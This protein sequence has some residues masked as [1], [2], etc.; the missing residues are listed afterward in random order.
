MNK[1][2][3]AFNFVWMLS[4]LVWIPQTRCSYS[5]SM[6][7]E[8]E[9]TLLRVP[10]KQLCDFCYLVMPIVRNLVNKNKTAHLRNIASY[11][12]FKK[13]KI[14]D[15]FVCESAIKEYEVF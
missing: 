5:S 12:C 6:S 8:F 2:L 4:V 1:L 14:A 13:F 15:E 9:K 10:N 3:A 11:L 7:N